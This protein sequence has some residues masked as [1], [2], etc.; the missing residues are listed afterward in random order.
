MSPQ[1]LDL[2]NPLP[3]DYCGRGLGRCHAIVEHGQIYCVTR[4]C[5]GPRASAPNTTAFDRFIQFLLHRQES[6][7][8][9]DPGN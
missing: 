9:N 7:S 8:G 2:F 1:Q 6:S 4:G 5:I 3:P